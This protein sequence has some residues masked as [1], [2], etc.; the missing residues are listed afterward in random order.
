MRKTISKITGKQDA[1]IRA[2]MLQAFARA[3]SFAHSHSRQLMQ[4]V[5]QY[6]Q[7]DEHCNM[8]Q[9]QLVALLEQ[10]V[11]SFLQNRSAV[12][13][14][15]GLDEVAAKRLLVIAVYAD[16]TLFAVADC[17]MVAGQAVAVIQK[18]AQHGKGGRFAEYTFAEKLRKKFS[19]KH[20]HLASNLT[21]KMF[22]PTSKR[23]FN[24][25]DQ[26]IMTEALVDET[27]TCDGMPIELKIQLSSQYMSE[28]L[29]PLLGTEGKLTKKLKKFFSEFLIYPTNLHGVICAGTYASNTWLHQKLVSDFRLPLF[30]SKAGIYLSNFDKGQPVESS[31]QFNAF[32]FQSDPDL[33]PLKEKQLQE[34]R[35]QVHA[36]QIVQQEIEVLSRQYQKDQKDQEEKL[37]YSAPTTRL[38]WVRNGNLANR[39]MTWYE[40]QKWV[41]SLD[42]AGYQDW[43][44]PTKD[45]FKLFTKEGGKHPSELFNSS[46]FN[47]VQAGY[48]WSSSTYAYYTGYAW[49]V[50]M[51]SGVVGSFSKNYYY[52]VWPVRGGQ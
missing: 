9:W 43:R 15:L 46:G 40:A 51:G 31:C 44:L 5:V 47:N 35:E 3:D 24:L 26:G 34:Q 28:M 10:E 4:P 45:E 52:Y 23:L 16:T 27:L 36:R 49:Y 33:S 14:K 6:I 39:K 37:L 32:S 38:Q 13:Q 21:D 42:Y 12:R 22:L 7:P 41:G 30:A 20:L 19:D 8:N 17:T 50:V 25:A 1:D 18:T 11:C 29:S 2:K 48:Y